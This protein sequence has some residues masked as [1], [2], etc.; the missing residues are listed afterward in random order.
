MIALAIVGL[1]LAAAF[2]TVNQVAFGGA[3]LRDK[4]FASWIAQNQI[5]ELRLGETWPEEGESNGEVEFSSQTWRWEARVSAT[6]V[7]TLRRIEVDIALAE[8]PE[9]II[10]TVAGFVGQTN[11]GAAAGTPWT[12]AVAGDIDGGIEQ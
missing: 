8:R 9:R 2:T 7:E 5:V 1:G 10:G 11:G 4:I 6:D 12:G 3:Y